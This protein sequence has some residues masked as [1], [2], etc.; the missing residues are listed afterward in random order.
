MRPMADQ[1]I[2][3][4]DLEFLLA[5]L[6]SGEPGG[7]DHMATA[8]ALRA[9]LDSHDQGDAAGEPGP[10]DARNARRV[11][12]A[13]RDF[14]DTRDGGRLDERTLPALDG[15]AN[16]GVLRVAAD[17]ARGLTLVPAG[18]GIDAV[19]ARLLAT[20]ATASI[21]GT[22]ER[23]KLC[24]ECRWAYFDRSRNRSRVWC[25]MASCG[26]RQKVRSYRERQRSP[27]QSSDGDGAG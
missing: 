24:G 17:P 13:I 8:E 22:L 23:I 16:A 20:L 15:A 2:H 7:T 14:L 19:F 1:T 6:N 4:R 12:A 11:R 25:D 5:F 9:W 26:T 10:E 3:E 21:L 18:R 27:R